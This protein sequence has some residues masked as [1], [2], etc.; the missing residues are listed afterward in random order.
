MQQLLSHFLLKMAGKAWKEAILHQLTHS[1]RKLYLLHAEKAKEAILSF[2]ISC[3]ISCGLSYSGKCNVPTKYGSTRR[4][5]DYMKGF[6]N[7]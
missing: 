2:Y 3:E 5:L 4:N 1:Q 7:G 6:G